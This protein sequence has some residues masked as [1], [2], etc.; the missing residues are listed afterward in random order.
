MVSQQLGLF[1][2]VSKVEIVVAACAHHTLHHGD[3]FGQVN[4]RDDQG[5]E[6]FEERRTGHVT[7]PVM[8]FSVFS[9][10]LGMVSMSIFS[11]VWG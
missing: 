10:V 6:M 11:Q 5:A 7:G 4:V 9:V 2:L 8:A 3:N 1:S